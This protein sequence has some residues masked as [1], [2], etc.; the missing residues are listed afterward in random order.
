LQIYLFIIN[1]DTVGGPE[2]SNDP[3]RYACGSEATG[4]VSL[5]GQ[6]DGDD[7]D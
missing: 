2:W 6:V 4:R 7:P 3:E 5:D 1:D